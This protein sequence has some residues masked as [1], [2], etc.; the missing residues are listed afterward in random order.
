MSRQIK[1][2]TIG[3]I[4]GISRQRRYQLRHIKDGLCILCSNK[5][6]GETNFCTFHRQKKTKYMRKVNKA[7]RIQH[8][9]EKA[10]A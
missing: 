7:N 2:D 1:P 10:K 4:P 5:N 9:K 3:K 6:D 8:A